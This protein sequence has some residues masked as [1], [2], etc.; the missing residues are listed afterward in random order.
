MKQLTIFLIFSCL[1]LTLTAQ[2]Q[3]CLG[4]DTTICQGQTV[5]ITNCNS[6]AVPGGG[7]YLNSPT[8]VPLGDD[9]WSG[10]INMGFTFSFY[11]VNY[12]QCVI[13]AN[14]IVSFNPGNAGQNCPWNLPTNDQ[15]ASVNITGALNA[16]MVAYQDLDPTD[17]DSGPVQYQTMGTAPNRKFVV[18]Y[19]GVTMFSCSGT[20]SYVG[21]IFYESTNVI[22]MFVGQ[23]GSCPGWNNG[24]AIQGTERS[25]GNL[26]HC[27]SGR[28]NTVWNATQD[29]RRW[30]P[31]AP[32]NTA[33]YVISQIP[34]VNINAPGGNMIWQN[35][36][37]QTFP[38]NNGVLN[39]NS[40][41]PGTTGYFLAG[42]SCGVSVG[43]V[44]DTTFI[45]RVT[46][47]AN[48]TTTSDFCSG[49]SG[50]ATATP[51]Q[52]SAPFQYLWTPGGQTT[53]TAV[54]LITG[55]YQVLVTDAN[56]C[57]KTVTIT[58][59]T[60]EAGF[61]GT[62]TD[63]SCPGGSDGTATV[64]MSPAQGTL[65]YNWF[66]ANG[67]TTATATGLSAGLYHCKIS[68]S[69]GCEDTV[70]VL[71]SEISPLIAQITNQ[72]NVTCYT[73]SDG[74]AE[75]SV[76]GGTAP[77]TYSWNT[78]GGT[79]AL[80]SV[81]PAGDHTVTITDANNCVV[82]VT[83][84]I[85]QPMPLMISSLT[86]DVVLCPDNSTTLT[87]QGTGGSTAYTYTWTENGMVIGTGSSIVVDPSN[88]GT[89]YCVELSEACG[90]PATDSCMTITFPT[91]IV[92]VFAP[93]V[94]WACQPGRFY[95][96]N[97]S[98]NPQEIAS[99][100]LE[101]GDGEQE[102]WTGSSDLIH[103]YTDPGTYNLTA[104]VTSVYGCIYTADFPGIVT[105]IAKPEADFMISSNPTTIF[106]TTVMIQDESSEGVISWKWESPGSIPSMSSSQNPIFDF[107]DGVIANYPIQLVVETPE[108][109][110]DT[111]ERILVVNSD[112]LFFAPN[113]FTPNED[114]Y[115]QTWK[116]FANGVD[117]YNFEV[118]IYNRW[119]EEIWK[120]TDVNGEWDGTYR[121]VL[122]PSGIYIWTARMKAVYSDDRIEY[123]GSIEVLR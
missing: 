90:S 57:T 22:E 45:T 106:E 29:G 62:S 46:V 34:Y 38:Y 63:V 104:T 102:L 80:N 109:C 7:L 97:L 49:G 83:T 93:D 108:G 86:P 88:S 27:T 118:S 48:T 103:E 42:T 55:N 4:S 71:V 54:N 101:Y 41:L 110:V 95:F 20:C 76:T 78:V 84:T 81:L 114:E 74:T 77:Y 58:V 72:S 75:V 89:T 11:G 61:S 64:Y 122:V 107:P 31:T 68:S 40:V 123:Q 36:L 59:P 37:G 15:L 67:Q 24:L 18:L 121:G 47:N 33:N 119:G 35:S 73:F 94:T 69:V 5:Q 87:V 65:T 14:G 2:V 6:G 85:S 13:G 113:A 53:Q 99:V 112:I 111:A 10:L 56:N 17:P 32:G 100:L 28:N 60:L 79:S 44:S 115:N 96:T 91:P 1:T 98:N 9:S 16:A 117:A 43:S 92:P 30:T 116:F 21:Y 25:D 12:T 51:L 50:T 120:T 70:E 52:G 66:D 82:S 26:A 3:L 23:K 105:V 39:I 19:N 8:N